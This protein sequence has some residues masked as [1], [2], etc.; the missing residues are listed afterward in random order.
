MNESEKATEALNATYNDEV[1]EEFEEET[2][3]PLKKESKFKTVIFVICLNN[4]FEKLKHRNSC[5]FRISRKM[6]K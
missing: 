6:S 3:V 4:F 2:Y 5:T 1:A